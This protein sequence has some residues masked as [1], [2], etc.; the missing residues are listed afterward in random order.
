MSLFIAASCEFRK[1]KRLWK[2][3]CIKVPARSIAKS[4]NLSRA[5]SPLRIRSAGES[6][7]SFGATTS[8]GGYLPSRII[9]RG[10]LGLPEKLKKDL[11]QDGF[12]KD[13]PIGAETC[14]RCHQDIVAQ[15]ETSAH[16]F[17]SFNNPFYEATVNDMRKNATAPNVW[18]EQ[19]VESFLKPAPNWHGE[20]QMV[21]RLPRSALMLA[22]KMD[23][24][25]DRNTG[26]RKPASPVSPATPLIRFTI[27]PATA[28]TTSPTS[29]KILIC[30]RPRKPAAPALICT[31]RRSKPSPRCTSARC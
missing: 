16:R 25:I 5:N 14:N 2:K 29:K 10:D 30:L 12:V 18:V 6:V 22:G 24:E 28:I 17:S 1:R 3:A 23:S 9:T 31:T 19:H 20:K 4:R 27:K 15:W 13:T 26:K 21:Q 8:S 7:L 11:E